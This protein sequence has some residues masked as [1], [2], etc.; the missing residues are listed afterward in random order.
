MRTLFNTVKQALLTPYGLGFGTLGNLSQGS[1]AKIF[2]SLLT[3]L[4]FLTGPS[5]ASDLPKLPQKSWSYKLHKSGS[6]DRGQLQ[7]GFQ[8]YKEVCSACH[9]MNLLTYRNLSALGYNAEE[10]KAIA[11]EYKVKDGPNDE[12]EMFERPARPEDKFVNP[13]ANEKAARA[14]NNGGLPPDLTLI[15]KARVG[16][17]DY[18]HALLTGY[19]P[20]PEGVQ[21]MEGMYYNA[22]F[23]G[24]Q[25]AMT[26][27]LA[28]GQV[29][30]SDG[31]PSTVDQMATDVTTFLAWAAEPEMERRHQMGIMVMIF[32]SILT[33]MLYAIMRRI[34]KQV[35]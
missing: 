14:A 19:T 28:E 4:T 15:V 6:F 21:V 24:G 29:T 31:T 16:G 34:W 20:P 30:Y 17:A 26:A 35:R 8:V 33:L 9:G 7:R 11:A 25:I 3:G 13:Y 2:V 5:E 10:I 18:I 32:L 1:K 23:P 22:Y 12:G 27:P